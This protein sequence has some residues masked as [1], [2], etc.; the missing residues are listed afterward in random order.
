MGHKATYHL[1][2][3][4]NSRIRRP[5]L[6]NSLDDHA[7][8]AFAAG[9]YRSRLLAKRVLEFTFPVSRRWTLQL[10][11]GQQLREHVFM[12]SMEAQ[13][14]DIQASLNVGGAVQAVTASFAKPAV[15]QRSPMEMLLVDFVKDQ[16]EAPGCIWS[17]PAVFFA[18]RGRT[19][20]PN[21][22]SACALEVVGGVRSLQKDGGPHPRGK[23]END[24]RLEPLKSGSFS[25]LP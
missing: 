1:P 16:L 13:S 5:E 15:T 10:M 2:S 18:R 7:W 23:P 19:E 9:Q 8:F 3:M 24:P 4:I 21:S 11:T 12:Y 6:L 14:Q 25:G 22:A 17:A 20:V